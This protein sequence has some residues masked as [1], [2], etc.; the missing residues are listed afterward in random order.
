MPY[1]EQQNR[2][3]GKVATAADTPEAELPDL[4]ET[5]LDDPSPW[6]I[7][8]VIA[9]LR[10][11][12]SG[13]QHP[14]LGDGTRLTLVEA[15]GPVMPRVELYPER[16]IV[17]F[18]SSLL[19]LDLLSIGQV[20]ADD[21]HVRFVATEQRARTTCVLYPDGALTLALQGTRDAAAATSLLIAPSEPDRVVDSLPANQPKE[22]PNRVVLSG[23]IG[24][25]PQVRTTAKGRRIA[26]VPLAVHDRES[27][28]W[29]TILFFDEAADNAVQSLAKGQLVT[30]VGYSHVRPV[31]QKTGGPREIEEIYAASIQTPK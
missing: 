23:R 7:P 5:F 30:V 2:G 25:E 19:R 1:H 29:K 12:P 21:D 10:A 17:R 24:R 11:Q 8:G 20:S 13:I 15:G 9:V 3:G 18:R 22:Q 16:L 14:L 6:D 31:A 4:S 27:T 26:R 28:V